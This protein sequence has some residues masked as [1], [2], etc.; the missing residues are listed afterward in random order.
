MAAGAQRA[1]IDVEALK[2]RFWPQA[3][4]DTAKESFEWAK[5]RLPRGPGS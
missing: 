4:I 2:Q 5:A 1:G 3:T